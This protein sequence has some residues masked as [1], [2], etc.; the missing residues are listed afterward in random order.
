MVD[1]LQDAV[2]RNDDTLVPM[3]HVRVVQH[4]VVDQFGGG[5]VSTW[6]DTTGE[7]HADMSQRPRGKHQAYTVVTTTRD[8]PDDTKRT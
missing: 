2:I 7:A 3:G 8:I 1:F 6:Y 5:Q 4:V